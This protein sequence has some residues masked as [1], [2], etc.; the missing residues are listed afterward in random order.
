MSTA[1]LNCLHEWLRDD[2]CDKEVMRKSD[3]LKESSALTSLHLLEKSLQEE[4]VPY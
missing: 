3:I 2:N 1:S 4:G